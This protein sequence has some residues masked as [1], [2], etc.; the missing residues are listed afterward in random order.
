MH[1]LKQMDR[2]VARLRRAELKMHDLADQLKEAT[3]VVYALRAQFDAANAERL[4]KMAA[5][6]G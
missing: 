5:K 1:T 6:K 2:M 4:A 3:R